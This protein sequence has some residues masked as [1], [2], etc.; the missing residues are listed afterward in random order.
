MQLTSINSKWVVL[1]LVMLFAQDV[2]SQDSSLYKMLESYDVKFYFLDLEVNN[3]SVNL[4]GKVEVLVE[5]VESDIDT[6]ALELNQEATVDSVFIGITKVAFVHSDD[7]LR[8][9][10]LPG[11]ERND[12]IQMIVFY[13]IQ[14][15]GTDRR[16]GIFNKQT[17]SGANV[18]YT[19]SEP[20]YSKSWFPCKQVL[21]DKADSVYIS[22]TMADSLMAG[23]NGILSDITDHDNNTKTYHWRS[24]YPIAYYLLSF[25]VADYMDYSFMASV[26]NGDSVLIQNYIYNDSLFFLENKDDIDAT[27]DLI[28]TFSEH[29]GKYPFRN[30]KYGH[31]IGPLG[32]GMEHQTMTTLGNFSFI[33]VAHELAH[34]W[35]GDYV[36][37][38]D[39]QNIWINEGFA[40][41]SEFI[42]TEDLKTKDEAVSWLRNTHEL[43]LSS[44][45]GSIFIPED[46]LDNASRIFD[47]S[48]TYRKGASIIHM[49]RHEFGDDELFFGTLQNFLDDFADSVA[50]AEDFRKALEY[51]SGQSFDTFFQQWF[52]G[53]GHPILNIAWEQKDDSLFIYLD[54]SV[55]TPDKTPFFN[56]LID[57]QIEYLN[58]DTLIQFRQDELSEVFSVPFNERVYRITPDPDNWLLREIRGINRIIPDSNSFFFLFPNPAED[59]FYIETYDIGKPYTVKIYNLNGALLRET[60]EMKVFA[61]INIS[62]LPA[63]IYKVVVSTDEHKQFFQLV[64][65]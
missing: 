55:S 23:S 40:S 45:S 22:L 4:Q 37:C 8:F 25:A 27:A 11:Y 47:Y 60:T 32:G 53:A 16:I 38:S 2:F 18:T 6:L 29:Y 58:G 15:T 14:D 42:A 21:T 44:P 54:Q 28:E 30:E 65:L 39:W 57:F 41:Y 10:V 5:L 59:I 63:G 33:L 52:Y 17:S 46:E 62:D 7:F 13:R 43:A 50:S 12:L 61:E 35:F 36:T 19:L 26:G 1:F 34:Q 20:F 51:Y 24:F 56:L 49:I 31:C 48:L 3:L 9:A 64:K